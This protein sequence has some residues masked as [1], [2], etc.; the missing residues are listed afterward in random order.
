VHDCRRYARYD[1]HCTAPVR[2][3]CRE[4][5]KATSWDSQRARDSDAELGAVCAIA[6]SNGS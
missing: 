6:E 3:P 2:I 1:L 5:S 4:V